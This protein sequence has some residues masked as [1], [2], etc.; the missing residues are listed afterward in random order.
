M[1]ELFNKTSNGSYQAYEA[2][3]ET[4]LEYRDLNYFGHEWE[5]IVAELIDLGKEYADFADIIG[6]HDELV[7]ARSL[8]DLQLV[9]LKLPTIHFRIGRLEQ[10]HRSIL[11]RGHLIRKAM[12]IKAQRAS[13]TE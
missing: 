2:A 11:H 8:E 4:E 13:Q 12:A 9:R 7:T 10:S 1:A 6:F 5:K 3:H